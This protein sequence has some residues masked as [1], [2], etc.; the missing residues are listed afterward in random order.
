MAV[1]S[2]SN[3]LVAARAKSERNSPTAPS[4]INPQPPAT[5]S[6]SASGPPNTDNKLCRNKGDDPTRRGELPNP[7]HPGPVFFE[8]G[9]E[10]FLVLWVPW[11]KKILTTKRFSDFDFNVPATLDV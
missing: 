8:G 1:I 10:K 5:T 11:N 2:C 6:L 4:P 3:Q 9:G 7:P